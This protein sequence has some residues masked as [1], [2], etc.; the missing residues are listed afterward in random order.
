VRVSHVYMRNHPDE[1]GST[2]HLLS[3]RSLI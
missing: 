1:M 3:E 2:S